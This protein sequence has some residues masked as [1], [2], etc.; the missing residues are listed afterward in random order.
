[1]LAIG[2]IGTMGSGKGTISDY[3]VKHYGFY[4]VIMGNIVRALARKNKIEINR[5]NLQDLAKKRRE[6]FGEDYFIDIAIEKAK[7]SKKDFILIDGV[8]T[9]RDAVKLK[10]QLGAKILMTDAKP[11]IRLERMKKRRRKGFAKTIEEFK[12]YEKNEPGYSELAKTLK[13]VDYEINNDGT[14]EEVYKNIDKLIKSI[15]K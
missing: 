11:E 12:F 13:H 4:R 9:L 1:M 3:L 5:K 10:E 2:I 14:K 15:K 6:E 8:R 7:K